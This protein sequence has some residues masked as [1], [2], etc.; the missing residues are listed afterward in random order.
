MTDDICYNGAI[1]ENLST[2]PFRIYKITSPFCPSSAF[3]SV[4]FMYDVYKDSTGIPLSIPFSSLVTFDCDML[5]NPETRP[6]DCKESLNNLIGLLKECRQLPYPSVVGKEVS[7]VLNLVKNILMPMKMEFMLETKYLKY[8]KENKIEGVNTGYMGIGNA[9]TWHGNPDACIR[10]C[11][12]IAADDDD[13]E[14]E[15]EEGEMGDHESEGEAS[16]DSDGNSAHWEAKRSVNFPKNIKQ[17]VASCVVSS[18]TEHNLHP[19]R[20]T[21]IPTVII[22]NRSFRVCLYDCKHDVL[23][24]SEDK[25]LSKINK[26]DVNVLSSTG[27]LFLW[28]IT[29]HR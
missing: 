9:G 6:C 3:T 11:N 16:V 12:I 1:W 20:N 5:E 29:N 22:D 21:L 23:L 14:E 17:L 2:F 19:T 18:F 24:I 8:L 4:D 15:E 7:I 28:I 13:D 10:G 27:L 25:Y 26:V